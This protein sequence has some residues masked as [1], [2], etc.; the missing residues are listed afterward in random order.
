MCVTY[1]QMQSLP[2]KGDN[3]SRQR[4]E[5][6]KLRLQDRKRVCDCS[7]IMI[8]IQEKKSQLMH[9]QRQ[10]KSQARKLC[11]TK[12]Q[13]QLPSS[14]HQA[15]PPSP[16]PSVCAP[17]AFKQSILNPIISVSI[18]ALPRNSTQEKNQKAKEK[19]RRKRKKKSAF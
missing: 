15:S 4:M 2:K 1:D 8:K 16:L 6:A 7:R 3:A 18:T 17:T 11:T 9:F 19:K 5:T 13:P 14:S 12:F 10:T